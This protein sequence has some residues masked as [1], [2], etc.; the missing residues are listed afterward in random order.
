LLDENY[1]KKQK[2]IQNLFEN[3]LRK[4]KKLYEYA[5]KTLKLFSKGKVMC[6]TGADI[7]NDIVEKLITG[8]RSWDLVEYPDAYIQIKYLVKSETSNYLQKEFRMVNINDFGN[9]YNDGDESFNYNNIAELNY[10]EILS[11]EENSELINIFNE[12]MANCDDD[13]QLVYLGIKTGQQNQEIAKDLGLS[14]SDVENI[15]KRIRRK[16]NKAFLFYK[17]N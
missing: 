5:D 11:R 6:K 9:D 2:L 7:V 17:N 12:E 15:K 8:K 3:E 16:L 14:V 10:T 13:C 4:C 1:E